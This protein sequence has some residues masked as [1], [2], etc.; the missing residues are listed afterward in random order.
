MAFPRWA[1]AAMALGTACAGALAQAKNPQNELDLSQPI[2]LERAIQIALKNHPS[3]G[4]A[5]SQVA[6][7]TARVTQSMAS[8]FPS[9]APSYTYSSQLSSANIGGISRTGTIEQGVTQISARQ[10]IFDT[11]KREEGVLSSR[12]SAKSSEYAYLDTR[13]TV[14]LN[15]TTAYYE[16]LRTRELV[17]VAQSNV[18]RA[19]TTL[20]STKAFAEEGTAPRKDILQAQADLDNAKVQLIQAE[21]NVRVQTVVLMHA[22]GLLT[23]A[24]I[25]VPEMQL[26]A[27]PSTPDP[28]P[29][30]KYVQVALA[31][32]M[33]ARRDAA[34]VDASRHQVKIASINAGLQ[35]EADV[36]EGYRVDPSPG[37]NRTFTTTFSYP[38]FDAG[39][40]RAQVRQAKASLEQA[41]K[42]LELTKHAIELDVEQAYLLREEARS[43][44]QA[45]LAA[46]RAA[47][48]NYDAATASRKE[49][50]GS[51]LDVITARN[52][53]VVAETNQVQAIYDYYTSDANLKRA[54]GENDVF[55]GGGS[56]K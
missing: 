56:S 53:L 30:E 15:V 52:A 7:A 19:Q 13:Q 38:L 55:A 11:G 27:P 8:Y 20:D 26:P 25:N 2:T 41:R 42:Q 44:V 1:V 54:L 14:I 16:L 49:G 23:M 12:Y 33:D 40:T 39:L 50:A 17:R 4:I 10:L 31:N 34:V 9:I 18:D 3:I 29:V 46:V 47:Q 6:A 28:E 43:R 5:K 45:A 32:R 37:E 22:M 35:V 48:E 36:T 21:N 51:I 24:P